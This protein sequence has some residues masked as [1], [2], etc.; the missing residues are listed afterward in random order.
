[1]AEQIDRIQL[2][3]QIQSFFGKGEDEIEKL[4]SKFGIKNDSSLKGMEFQKIPITKSL[5]ENLSMLNGLNASFNFKLDT[6]DGNNFIYGLFPKISKD[7]K[8][9]NNKMKNKVYKAFIPSGNDNYMIVDVK[10]YNNSGNKLYASDMTITKDIFKSPSAISS[11]NPNNKI[12]EK[13]YTMTNDGIQ[14]IAN[15]D[16]HEILK[17]YS[18]YNISVNKGSIFTSPELITM[19]IN[20]SNQSVNGN[21]STDIFNA[22]SLQTYKGIKPDSVKSDEISNH[23][24]IS[25]KDLNA[26]LVENNSDFEIDEKSIYKV[27]FD[28]STNNVKNLEVINDKLQGGEVIDAFAFQN[29]NLSRE[30]VM[31]VV[32]YE[33]SKLRHTLTPGEIKLYNSYVNKKGVD[34]LKLSKTLAEQIVLDQQIKTLNNYNF[35]SIIPHEEI[36]DWKD[37]KGKRAYVDAFKKYYQGKEHPTGVETEVYN[38]INE[39]LNVD[40]L[41]NKIYNGETFDNFLDVAK[42][43]ANTV[44]KVR[45][46]SQA[47]LNPFGYMNTDLQRK[48]QA[49]DKYEK[50]FLT[51]ANGEDLNV[52]QEIT[53]M[54]ANSAKEFEY[55]KVQ[56]N[57]EQGKA[58]NKYLSEKSGIDVPSTMY[59]S[60]ARVLYTD[61]PLAFQDSDLFTN[62]FSM[63]NIS[64]FNNKR[65]MMIKYNS[66]SKNVF[67]NATDDEIKTFLTSLEK[68]NYNFD[69]LEDTTGIKANFLRNLLGEENYT[70]YINFRGPNN[71][72]QIADDLRD[73]SNSFKSIQKAGGQIEGNEKKYIKASSEATGKFNDWLNK[74][75]IKS[76]GESSINILNRDAVRRGVRTKISGSNYGFINN[77]SFTK[78]GI[79]LDLKHMLVQSGGSKV[80]LD[81][82]KATTQALTDLI[83]FQPDRSTKIFVEGVINEKM[84]KG[85]RGFSGTFFSR[86][87]NTMINR[88]MSADYSIDGKQ[89]VT[90]QDKFDNAMNI[91][92]NN[93]APIGPNG[94]MVNIF[95]L[96]NVDFKFDN[97]T[98]TITFVDKNVQKAMDYIDY[99]KNGISFNSLILS[100][101]NQNLK[102]YYGKNFTNEEAKVLGTFASDLLYSGYDQILSQMTDES[103]TRNQIRFE[104][105]KILKS[106]IAGDSVGMTEVQKL[107]EYYDTKN[108]GY[109]YIFDTDIYMMHESKKRAIEDGLKLGRL[110]GLTLGEID[111]QELVSVIGNKSKFQMNDVM[112]SYMFLAAPKDTAFAR[113]T[114][115]FNQF[116]DN[117]IDMTDKNI[118]YTPFNMNVNIDTYLQKSLF[119]RLM[120]FNIEKERLES[121][122]KGILKGFDD[123]YISNLK[124]FFNSSDTFKDLGRGLAYSLADLTKDEAFKN[125]V[126]KHSNSF[127][128][129]S[130]FFNNAE[131]KDKLKEFKKST[132]SDEKLSE[133]FDIY[134][135]KLSRNDKRII[136]K[137]GDTGLNGK[138]FNIFKAFAS[139]AAN[140]SIANGNNLFLGHEDV[141]DS[142][143]KVNLDRSTLNSIS[144]FYLNQRIHSNLSS[145]SNIISA[146]FQD[147]S[148]FKNKNFNNIY[149]LK[150]IAEH[151]N[152]PF[153]IDNISI[154]EIGGIVPNKLL[155][156]LEKIQKTSFEISELQKL[157]KFMTSDTIEKTNAENSRKVL[158]AFES[159]KIKKQGNK[160]FG[161]STLENIIKE[162]SKDAY[163]DVNFDLFDNK[164]FYSFYKEV[165]S[166]NLEISSEIN[167]KFLAYLTKIK[168]S[169]HMDAGLIGL[170]DNIGI[171]SSDVASLNTTTKKLLNSLNFN[172]ASNTD[173]ISKVFSKLEFAKNNLVIKNEDESQYNGLINFEKKLID[174]VGGLYRE[175]A[176]GKY[177]ETVDNFV[178]RLAAGDFEK[179]SDITGAITKLRVKKVYLHSL[180]QKAKGNLTESLSDQIVRKQKSLTNLLMTRNNSIGE[181]I[182]KKGG[183]VYD[184]TS[185]SIID[186]A[187][188]SPREGSAITSFVKREL[189]ST[190]RTKDE[191]SL[192]DLKDSL[193]LIYGEYDTE[194]IFKEIDT[195]FKTDGL[196]P[197]QI[198]KTADEIRQKLDKLSHIV[199]GDQEMYERIGQSHIFGENR[200]VAYGM[201]SRHPHQY[202][203]SVSPTRFV[204]LSEED[205]AK[206]F[207]GKYLGTGNTVSGTQ[208]TLIT[209]GKKTALSA[210]G[211]FDGDVFQVMFLGDKDLDYM[212]YANMN[213]KT[214]LKRYREKL[215]LLN[216]LNNSTGID[217][218]SEFLADPDNVSVKGFK[219]AKLNRMKELILKTYF[220]AND[221]TIRDINISNAEAYGAIE[222][223]FLSLAHENARVLE[224]LSDEAEE[225]AQ[226]PK[227]LGEFISKKNKTN[228]IS[229]FAI[230]E[231]ALTL[232]DELRNKMLM[233]T[234]SDNELHQIITNNNRVSESTQLALRTSYKSDNGLLIKQ[235]VKDLYGDQDSIAWQQLYRYANKFKDD[236]GIY[237]TPIVHTELT[238]FRNS[239]NTLMKKEMYG[240]AVDYFINLHSNGY[241]TEKM[242]FDRK[243]LYAAASAHDLGTLIEKLAISSK[244]GSTSPDLKIKQ[245][246]DAEKIMVGEIK[247]GTY[248]SKNISFNYNKIADIVTGIERNIVSNK[249][250]NEVISSDFLNNNF[251]E[252]FSGLYS[253]ASESEI[254]RLAKSFLILGNVDDVESKIANKSL[255]I[256]DVFKTISKNK[257]NF[258]NVKGLQ[259]STLLSN[260]TYI[261]FKGQLEDTLMMNNDV[262]SPIYKAIFSHKPVNFYSQINKIINVAKDWASNKMF[263]TREEGYIVA[264]SVANILKIQEGKEIETALEGT[265]AVNNVT[266]DE[267]L[268]N[269]LNKV[270]EQ[271]AKIDGAVDNPSN[272]NSTTERSVNEINNTNS[273]A[274]ISSAKSGATTDPTVA[275][276]I[277]ENQ[278]AI[279]K[280]KNTIENLQKDKENVVAKSKKIVSRAEER[281]KNKISKLQEQKEKIV[282]KKNEQISRLKQEIENL[283]T[284]LAQKKEEVATKQKTA[285]DKITERKN[286]EIERILKKHESEKEKIQK[287]FEREKNN[288][289]KEKKQEIKRIEKEKNDE[290]KKITKSKDG[291]I[292]KVKQ[293]FKNEIN[294][295]EKQSSK[296]SN[297]LN[298]LIK[299]HESEKAKLIKQNQENIEQIKNEFNAEKEKIIAKSKE[300][301]AKKEAKITELAKE[302]ELEKSQAASNDQ[303]ITFKAQEQINNLINSHAKEKEEL[304]NKNN[305]EIEK[306]KE[307]LKN[308]FKVLKEKYKVRVKELKAEIAQLKSEN[309][310]AKS[311]SRTIRAARNV[312]NSTETYAERTAAYVSNSDAAKAVKSFSSKHKQGL[313]IAGGVATLAT[314]FRIFQSNRPVVNLDISEKEYERSQGS[315][316]R[317]LGQ[318]TINTNIRSLY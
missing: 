60:K 136:E 85:S 311:E 233:G 265:E 242:M 5:T 269:E 144:Q 261:M 239:M 170:L 212:K 126:E 148:L 114:I 160:A 103:R 234:I 69:T 294:N 124:S 66:L 108:A 27:N 11:K 279:N 228:R 122:L 309:R 224:T 251:Y 30:R 54:F 248:V 94:S 138:A 200:Q 37:L 4:I 275:Q 76:D 211:D 19:S 300:V 96:F 229:K 276:K 249:L 222:N 132:K 308:N 131:I 86:S 272:I 270:N 220:K 84:T 15:Q 264:D 18:E 161:M 297:E 295:Y 22:T 292:L 90:M 187:A 135:N 318:Y 213:S 142:L 178:N 111:L 172:F 150:E 118:V 147:V 263:G 244:K 16:Y 175:E 129:L 8:E 273:D 260:W 193:R 163:L 81:N 296:E 73:I 21:K 191:A 216:M 184:A 48:A 198:N 307:E 10:L 246:L 29:K 43:S 36:K 298:S 9:Q 313:M 202:K 63:Q 290:I 195:A 226:M 271:K 53:Q 26:V 232:P 280:Q 93:K 91:L 17:R 99:A 38:Y 2:A 7:V 257:E 40:L 68:N 312:I 57:Y 252:W 225:H 258:N 208:S 237:K 215:E 168:D 83:A 65:P 34:R 174:F 196:K 317:N 254:E 56:F 116:F 201:L 110:S 75:F 104:K 190:L 306:V 255:S 235:S 169:K 42:Q 137:F 284:K 113:G 33:N 32:G 277:E 119:G 205:K 109:A 266:N 25:G 35:D 55:K 179:E 67:G 158:E 314:F 293:Q 197:T 206:S 185:I 31:E 207:I 221:K 162:V 39:H 145:N 305:K 70:K 64:M 236:V 316:Y 24:F 189:M 50:F 253:N 120:D 139:I 95:D 3:P 238:N 245:F 283:K 289:N 77:V 46:I 6:N 203:L 310:K 62:S 259:F 51:M 141:I 199:I 101:M 183:A 61:T 106:Y 49:G 227:I 123:D 87:L 146:L 140:V 281:N 268:K 304:I 267:A 157:K 315:L 186:S 217:L 218:R 47:E 192:K 243:T 176:V 194:D 173:F 79:V 223:V 23:A 262:N 28:I 121:P 278:T 41:A 182:F 166:K 130:N 240:K 230:S 288:F 74:Y 210:K 181:T 14:V 302:L 112:K 287:K 177:D 256:L 45:W 303:R 128:I 20:S 188:V 291:E 286:K 98:N 155:S 105:G 97:H 149:E 143:N 164:V 115:G 204:M 282:N 299:N 89:L 71:T 214:F 52:S 165:G 107:G 247:K 285:V 44:G 117:V 250:K 82:V 151:G 78:D 171:D 154:D 59:Q 167:K 92:R 13:V 58:L 209:I 152:I 241:G 88:S 100:S 12:V 1:M 102:Q 156:H 133:L 219:S 159:F 80:M 231:L 180:R 134:I 125:A 274:N 127:D 301:L 72:T 153:L